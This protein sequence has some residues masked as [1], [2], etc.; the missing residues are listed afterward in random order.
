MASMAATETSNVEFRLAPEPLKLRRWPL[1]DDFPSLAPVILGGTVLCWLVAL[2][3]DWRFA[4]AAAAIQLAVLW[5]HLV[6]TTYELNASGVI[7][8][9]WKSR[10]VPWNRVVRAEAGRRGVLLLPVNSVSSVARLRGIYIPWG[11][12]EAAVRGMLSYYLSPRP[13]E[14]ESTR[15]QRKDLNAG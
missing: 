3:T 1:V 7:I 15:G 8:R 10:V 9:R 12:N 2:R 13:R 5:R 6:P 11:D 4:A 14:S